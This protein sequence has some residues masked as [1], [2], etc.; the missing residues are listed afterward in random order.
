MQTSPEV[1]PQ[2]EAYPVARR[3]PLVI[4]E[5]EA[6]ELMERARLRLLEMHYHSKVGH[7]GGNL[8]ALDILMSLYH[9]RLGPDDGFVLSKGHA[10]GA[11]YVTLWTM[12]LL[13]DD[14]LRHFHG[15]GTRLSGHPPLKGVPEVIF[16]T[17]SLG[18]GL[19]LA[20]GLALGKKLR[21]EPGRIFCLTSDGEWNEGSCW[22]AL[23]FLAHQKLD[24]LTFLV[25]MNGM[26]GFG[27]TRQVANLDSLADKFR[28]FGVKTLEVDGH[29]LSSICTALDHSEGPLGIVAKTTKGHGV[30]FMENQMAWH[31]L[32][33][34]EEQYQQALLEVM[35]CDK[36][37]V[38]A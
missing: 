30:S 7:I 25:D 12:G 2:S 9:F 26:Q 36:H 6:A 3:V 22:E 4:G 28:A 31:Y 20:A 33:M 15:E 37:S 18:H 17:G 19:S 24:N 38:V 35:V 21:G 16:A 5:T 32:P 13:S 11:L 23:I 27:S 29:D 14:D 1:C 8:S 10:A 34:N